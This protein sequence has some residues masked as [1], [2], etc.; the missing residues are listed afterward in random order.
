MIAELERMGPGFNSVLD[1]MLASGDVG[2]KEFG[3]LMRSSMGLAAAG[4]TSELT[5]EDF[6]GVVDKIFTDAGIALDNNTAVQNAATNTI[7]ETKTAADTQVKNSNFKAVG[8]DIADGVATGVTNGSFSVAAAM[9]RL[10]NSALSAARTA[11]DSHSPARKFMPLG[12]DIDEGVALPI[13]KAKFTKDAAQSLIEKTKAAMSIS[14]SRMAN[15]AQSGSSVINLPPATNG[16]DYETLANWIWKTA[17]D[18]NQEIVM[19]AQK[20]GKLVEPTVSE[21]QANKEQNRG[22]AR[23]WSPSMA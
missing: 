14:Q 11:A 9:K 5:G 4:A 16:I 12:E 18:F 7:K 13:E 20:V 6:P 2:T 10:V 8:N 15:T 3:E 1:E 22:R 19:D 23:G 17:P 21:Q